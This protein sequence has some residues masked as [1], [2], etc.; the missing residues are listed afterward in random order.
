[1]SGEVG[2][3]SKTR[4]NNDIGRQPVKKALRL[5]FLADFST[6]APMEFTLRRIME[7]YSSG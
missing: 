6:L 1:V 5:D 4:G 3:G 2:L 7:M